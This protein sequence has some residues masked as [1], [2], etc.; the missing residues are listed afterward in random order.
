MRW[1]IVRII[2]AGKLSK[3]I[4][5]W[6]TLRYGELCIGQ[7]CKLSERGT[8]WQR[9]NYPVCTVLWLTQKE[10]K[11]WDER[12]VRLEL[13]HFVKRNS[14]IVWDHGMGI[15]KDG[16]EKKSVQTRIHY[17]YS[18]LHGFLYHLSEGVCEFRPFCSFALGR[19]AWEKRC[20]AWEKGQLA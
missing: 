17:L 8:N 6:V 7:S 3:P 15:L 19:S 11:M 14:T 1:K 12:W 9:S 4:L 5:C 20:S 2:R 16:A 13:I 10:Y 18:G